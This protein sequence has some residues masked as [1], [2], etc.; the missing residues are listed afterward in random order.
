[1]TEPRAVVG[2]AIALRASVRLPAYAPRPAVALSE[3]SRGGKERGAGSTLGAPVPPP[4]LAIT[5][6]GTIDT[7]QLA[8]KWEAYSPSTLMM[9]RFFR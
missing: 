4:D 5:Q 1:M 7:K 8:P 6:S 2:A 3:V 9:T